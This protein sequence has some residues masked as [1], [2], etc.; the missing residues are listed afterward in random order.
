MKIIILSLI[1]GLLQAGTAEFLLRNQLRQVKNKNPQIA[2]T[3]HKKKISEKTI[4]AYP[5]DLDSAIEKIEEI[6]AICTNPEDQEKARL[7]TIKAIS[8]IAKDHKKLLKKFKLRT[9]SKYEFNELGQITNDINFNPLI[10]EPFIDEKV[11]REKLKKIQY[12]NGNEDKDLIKIVSQNYTNP[13]NKIKSTKKKCQFLKVA[14]LEA[15]WSL[16]VLKPSF[17][18]KPN[19]VNDLL[20]SI[21]PEFEEFKNYERD[22]LRASWALRNFITLNKE[23]VPKNCKTKA[24]RSIYDEAMIRFDSVNDSTAQ[25]KPLGF[26]LGMCGR[27]MNAH[28][29]DDISPERAELDLCFSMPHRKAL[30]D[31][32]ILL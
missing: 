9:H 29:F 28:C 26:A 5:Q 6:E 32:D 21:Q 24:G 7:E 25:K 3:C 20:L 14:Y 4:L 19:T 18:Y 8:T 31:G 15:L 22:K 27:S 17:N 13:I 2:M 10:K 16:T 30:L 11:S 1:S 23:D 12:Y